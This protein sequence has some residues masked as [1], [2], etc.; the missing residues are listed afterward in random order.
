[1]SS[2]LTA[3]EIKIIQ[4]ERLWWHNESEKQESIRRRFKLTPVRYYQLLNALI[5]RPAA[6]DYDPSVVTRLHRI[7][8]DTP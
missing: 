3:Q 7:R 4:F 1:M 6:L 2:Q 5:D 8:K